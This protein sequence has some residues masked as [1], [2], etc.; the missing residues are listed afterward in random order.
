MAPRTPLFRPDRFFAEREFHAGRILAV[1]GLVLAS[2]LVTVYGV[3]YL[4]VTHID[5]TVLVDNPDR[6][7]EVVC[8]TGMNSSLYNESNCA[9]PEEI[10]QNVDPIIWDA[11]ERLAGVMLGGLLLLI[12]GL[13]VIL[14][15][16]SWLAGGTNGGAESFAVTV[17]GLA[18][19]LFVAPIGV[20]AL[21]VLIEPVTLSAAQDPASAFSG[22]ERR[23]RANQWIGSTLTAASSVWSGVIWRFGLE[24]KR[25]LDGAEATALAGAVALLFLLV[26]A[27]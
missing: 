16:G 6:P 27:L 7:P 25:G 17:W 23:I 2:G 13:S 15:V 10:E 19:T 8:D 22:V 26:G 5:G 24:H 9:A 4:M 18:P 11:I 20:L 1:F 21:S 3:G 12:A 14:H